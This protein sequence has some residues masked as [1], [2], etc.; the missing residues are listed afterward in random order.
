MYCFQHLKETTI[1][2]YNI[3]IMAKLVDVYR[4]DSKPLSRRQL[5]LVVDETLTV[6][7]DIH[8]NICIKLTILFYLISCEILHVLNYVCFCI[9]LDGDGS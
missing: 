3:T 9:N 7:N 6:I 1:C 2:L 8:Y 5:P 4:S